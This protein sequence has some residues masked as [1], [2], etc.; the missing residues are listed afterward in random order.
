Y[1]APEQLTGAPTIDARAD[2][3]AAGAVFYELLTYRQAFPG[4]MDS[5]ILHRIIAADPEPLLTVDPTLDRDLV[6]IVTR[7]L[8][9]SPENRYPDMAAVR[10]HLRGV[11]HPPPLDADDEGGEPG[12][13]A[14][15]DRHR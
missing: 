4:G 14:A 9:K 12:P 13:P 15:L 7:C 10:R 11:L 8:A 6:D 1:M 5:G 2:M 3:W